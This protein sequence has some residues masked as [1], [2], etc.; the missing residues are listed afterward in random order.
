M[1]SKA[2]VMGR[3]GS[4]PEVRHIPNGKKVASVKVGVTPNIKKGNNKNTMW[5]KVVFLESLKK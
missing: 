1:L 5:H 2:I 3:L 4:D